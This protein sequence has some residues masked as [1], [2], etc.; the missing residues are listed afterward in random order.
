MKLLLGTSNPSKVRDYKKYL[1]HAN[2]ELVTTCDLGILDEPLEIGKTYQ[3]TALQKAQ[4]Y[5]KQS[6]YPTLAEDGG[7]EADG[8]DGRPGLESRRWVGPLGTDE[9]RLQKVFRLLGT[10]PNR[11]ARLKFVV[12]VYFPDVRDHVE[13][14]SAIEGI[15][16]ESP[17]PS[18]M[19]QFPYRS[20]LFL[21]Q[22]KKYYV[23]L[24][25]AELEE[26]DHRKKASRE[27]LLKL[28]PYLS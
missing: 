28:E 9:E 18:R 14:E 21:P 19:A 13:V 17:S 22:Y 24:N 25:P 8:L 3:E 20:A 11:T 23:D 2:L 16:P 27:L 12:V 15:I 7:F 5:A 10:N 26:V 6:E 4:F 1:V